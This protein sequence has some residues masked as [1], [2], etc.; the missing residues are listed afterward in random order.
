[1]S[2]NKTITATSFSTPAPLKVVEVTLTLHSV[3]LNEDVF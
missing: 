3:E 2:L 1:M